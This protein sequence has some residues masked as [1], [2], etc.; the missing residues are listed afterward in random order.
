[1]HTY[2][3]VATE[4][5]VLNLVA[6]AALADA[7]DL[8]VVVA[9]PLA[10]RRGWH[11]SLARGIQARQLSVR[12]E[13][14]PSWS[15]SDMD[16]IVSGVTRETAG[17]PVPITL[18]AIGGRKHDMLVLHDLLQRHAGL[19]ESNRQRPP[20]RTISID[21]QPLMMRESTAGADGVTYRSLPLEDLPWSRRVTLDD[22][23][24]VHGYSRRGGTY[25][26]PDDP[27][28]DLKGLRSGRRF[29]AYVAGLVKRA[30]PESAAPLL[31][32]LWWGVTI[33]PAGGRNA[34][35]EFDVL[36]LACDASVVHFE[37][38]ADS[39]A[40]M[41]RKT[42]QMRRIFTPESQLVLCHGV[43]G[44]MDD[45]ELVALR[46]R[47]CNQYENLGQFE[48]VLMD[49]FSSPRSRVSESIPS[50]AGE[51]ARILRG[52]WARLGSDEAGT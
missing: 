7:G 36:L 38:K 47:I 27:P 17:G 25:I 45:A 6:L 16:R 29:E 5:N 34:A 52:A 28:P 20:L 10:V 26:G 19:L 43:R 33:V 41:Q 40:G 11:T 35:T 9:D 21:R 37:C 51:I 22:V 49:Q 3:A 23:L 18:L 30:L 32:A 48:L 8:V 1:M 39:A 13:E 42:F 44:D 46:R 24:A 50:P 2:I 15:T 14:L 12:I 4:Y 31:N